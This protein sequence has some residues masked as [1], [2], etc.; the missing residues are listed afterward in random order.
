MMVAPWLIRRMRCPVERPDET[1]GGPR[2]TGK[3]SRAA[4][5]AR[6]CVFPEDRCLSRARGRKGPHTRAREGALASQPPAPPHT[7]AMAGSPL[8]RQRKA[9]IRDD[10]PR[11]SLRCRRGTSSL[12]IGVRA[13]LNGKLCREADRERNCVGPPLPTAT[14]RRADAA[15]DEAPAYSG[16]PG[17][18]REGGE[19]RGTEN[20]AGFWLL[21]GCET[22]AARQLLGLSN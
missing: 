17:L 15:A 4:R 8:K 5:V 7:R 14:Q 21:Y 16:R 3:P 2:G 13:M 9:G 19:I 22:A 20:S 10:D 6:N 18:E 11:L 12:M 1:C